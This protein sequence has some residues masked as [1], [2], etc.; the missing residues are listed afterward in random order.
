MRRV[1][2]LK[3]LLPLIEKSAI[4]LGGWR[5]PFVPDRAGELKNGQRHRDEDCVGQI[6]R[7]EH[8][9]EVW[10]FYGSGQFALATSVGWDWRDESGW[11]PVRDGEEWSPNSSIGI[12]HIVQMLLQTFLFASRIAETPAGDE[13]IEIEVVLAPTMGR[14]LFSDFPR[15]ML[16]PGYKAD[17]DRI[18]VPVEVTR[19]EL[20]ASVDDLAA[21]TANQVFGEFGFKPMANI[22]KELVAEVRR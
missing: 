2:Q 13:K 14:E 20:L 19:T 16:L 21:A 3:E 12:G 1:Q 11:W 7:W 4:E 18:R 5:F 10:R 8:H 6:H 22:L 15:R 9:L 17:I